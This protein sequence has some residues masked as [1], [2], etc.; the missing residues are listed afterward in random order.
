MRHAWVL[1]CVACLGCGH[2]VQERYAIDGSAE[3][4]LRTAHATANDLG[5]T[6]RE[7][8]SGRFHVTAFPRRE[9]DSDLVIDAQ[10]GALLVDGRGNTSA[11]PP[12][13]KTR[14][15]EA[16]ALLA[17][18]TDARLHGS[19]SGPPVEP[20]SKGLAVALDLL[21]P[22]AGGWYAARGDPYYDSSAVSWNRGFWMDFGIRLGM[23]AMAA[24]FLAEG[25]TF[26]TVNGRNTGLSY[27]LIAGLMAV[28]DRLYA[29]VADVRE[30]DYRNAWAA[31][32]IPAPG[33]GPRPPVQYS[34]R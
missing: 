20:R 7:A 21:L 2:A 33:D 11:W 32:R 3:E 6:T 27:L 5:W 18:G 34:E 19:T 29:V 25:L 1:T 30:I 16:S 8:G 13:A 26:P 15:V 23:D 22:A 14:L 4:L 31:S 9:N 28:L 17:Y 10:D 24:S 12:E